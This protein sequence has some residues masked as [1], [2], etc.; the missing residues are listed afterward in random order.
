MGDSAFL[1]QFHVD[2]RIKSI[3]FS[4]L[5]VKV[6]IANPTQ[7]WKCNKT[8]VAIRRNSSKMQSSQTNDDFP[9]GG[10]HLLYAHDGETKCAYINEFT[11]FHDF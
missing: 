1:N 2:M 5:I 11:C 3:S 4:I 7:K 6:E 9:I 8:S 10:S